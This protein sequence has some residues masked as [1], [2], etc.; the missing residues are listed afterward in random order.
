MAPIVGHRRRKSSLMQPVGGQSVHLGQVPARSITP[1]RGHVA[2][3]SVAEQPGILEDDED[4]GSP[5]ELDD[6]SRGSFSDEDLNEDE[7]MGLTSGERAEKRKKRQ[8]SMRL[9][10][11]IVPEKSPSPV[12]RTTPDQSLMRQIMINGG[13]ILLWYL[14]SLSLSLVS[15]VIIRGVCHMLVLTTCSITNG[16]LTRAAS[17]SNSPSLR[18]RCICWCSLAWHRLCCTLSRHYALILRAPPIMGDQDTKKNP[19]PA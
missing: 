1:S 11:R 7:E 14:F 4:S 8:R 10:Q 9:D 16:C 12:A 17:T 5:F 3:S 18:R 13:L 19:I 2:S 6:T 15:C